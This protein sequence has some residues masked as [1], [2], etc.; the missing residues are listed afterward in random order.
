MTLLVTPFNTLFSPS[1]DTWTTVSTMGG[2]GFTIP[3][4]PMSASLCSNA[5]Y[6]LWSYFWPKYI[7]SNLYVSSYFDAYVGPFTNTF[8]FN[9]SLDPL[10]E[11]TA[12]IDRMRQWL[13]HF[14]LVRCDP[15]DEDEFDVVEAVDLSLVRSE[16][17]V[18]LGFIFPILVSI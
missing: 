5:L 15:L 11:S 1:V 12:T 18:P 17:T 2:L 9:S 10:K 16:M 3:L 8:P 14:L 7:I 13:F 6:T 4:H